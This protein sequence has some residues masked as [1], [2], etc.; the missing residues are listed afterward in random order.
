M[1]FKT[2]EITLKSAKHRERMRG[3]D[4]KYHPP[5]PESSQITGSG[6]G[7]LEM[8]KKD[9]EGRV[10]LRGKVELEDRVVLALVEAALVHS[11]R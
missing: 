5:S 9:T 6:C 4:L 2:E 10:V 7:C 3:C 1:P 8:N 11:K